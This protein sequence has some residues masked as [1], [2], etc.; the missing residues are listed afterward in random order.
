MGR[1][2]T[3]VCVIT[4][5]GENS[6][7]IG[8]TVNSF[9][10]LSLDPPLILWNLGRNSDTFEVFQTVNRFAVNVLRDTQQALSTKFS[11]PNAHDMDPDDYVIGQSGCPVLTDALA[12]FECQLESRL[13]GGDHV[14]LIGRATDLRHCDSGQ[15]LVFFGG[16]YRKLN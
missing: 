10:S 5:L 4:T 2:A 3:G 12:I 1:F 9:S 13:D 14:I 7:P 16:E 6:T 15:P 8:L 11:R